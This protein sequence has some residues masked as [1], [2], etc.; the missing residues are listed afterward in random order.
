MVIAHKKQI[1]VA[2]DE[3]QHL[4]QEIFAKPALAQFA[5]RLTASGIRNKLLTIKGK[6]R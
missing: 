6:L 1:S 4:D 5:T 3:M 2:V